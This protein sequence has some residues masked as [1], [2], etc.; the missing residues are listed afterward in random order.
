MFN[1]GAC[2]SKISKSLILVML[3]ILSD[4]LSLLWSCVISK[5][6]ETGGRE[7]GGGRKWGYNEINWFLLTE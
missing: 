4:A 7:G 3:D 5:A 6:E 1:K 2:I